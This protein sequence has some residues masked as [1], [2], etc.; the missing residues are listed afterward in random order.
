PT[1]R[2]RRQGEGPLSGSDFSATR[3]LCSRSGCTCACAPALSNSRAVCVLGWCGSVSL[4]SRPPETRAARAARA[5][6]AARAALPTKADNRGG[7]PKRGGSLFLAIL[8]SQWQLP[9]LQD[10]DCP[11]HSVPASPSIVPSA[12]PIDRYILSSVRNGARTLAMC[13]SIV[14]PDSAGSRG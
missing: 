1:G 10:L 5:T 12:S 8:P 3:C 13:L 4:P 6:R 7:Q 9:L 14:T 11:L 2:E